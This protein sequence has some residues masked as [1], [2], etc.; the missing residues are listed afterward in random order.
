MQC[1]ILSRRLR[2]EH[3]PLNKAVGQRPSQGQRGRRHELDHR[4]FV[5]FRRR[6]SRDLRDYGFRQRLTTRGATGRSPPSSHQWDTTR[7]PHETR[8]VG[9]LSARLACEA[10]R[11]QPPE[12]VAFSYSQQPDETYG[13]DLRR[14][15]AT[16]C[17]RKFSPA[18]PC[19][20]RGARTRLHCRRPFAAHPGPRGA[21]QCLSRDFA[22]KR[23]SRQ[24]PDVRIFV[25]KVA[26]SQ[27]PREKNS[28]G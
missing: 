20:T 3:N 19:R 17:D 14:T 25:D 9:A 23:R 27:S 7:V 11:S 26:R 10:L 6:R 24:D 15:R 1:V 4:H 13:G 2:P 12:H 21:A 22:R 16:R 8:V 28:L 18:D 5:D